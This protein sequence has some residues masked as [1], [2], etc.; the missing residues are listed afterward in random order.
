MCICMYVTGKHSTLPN[1][2]TGYVA[3][4]VEPSLSF[5]LNDPALFC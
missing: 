4:N 2:M 1:D 5:L 3:A